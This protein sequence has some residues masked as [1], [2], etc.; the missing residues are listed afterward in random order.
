MIEMKCE[1]CGCCL[2]EK[3]DNCEGDDNVI[4]SYLSIA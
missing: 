2:V 3:D 4:L 1:R